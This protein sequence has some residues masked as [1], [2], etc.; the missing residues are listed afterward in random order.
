VGER[1]SAPLRI[2]CPPRWTSRQGAIT[3][4]RHR[5]IRNWVPSLQPRPFAWSGER[6]VDGAIRCRQLQPSVYRRTS[7][8]GA[9]SSAEDADSP[10]TFSVLVEPSPNHVDL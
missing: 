4:L 8:T 7:E 3:R 2:S 1:L 10:W 9:F 6:R 5:H